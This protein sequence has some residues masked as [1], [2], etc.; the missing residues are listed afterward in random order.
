MATLKSDRPDNISRANSPRERS[1]LCGQRLIPIPTVWG[2]PNIVRPARHGHAIMFRECTI[3]M[4]ATWRVSKK[5]SKNCLK[6]KHSFHLEMK[7]GLQ[8]S[9][10]KSLMTHG[11]IQRSQNLDLFPKN[12][13]EVG[14]M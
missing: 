8:S 7:V 14:Y 6:S 2:V 10:R 12:Q 13:A 5:S 11:S 4:D 9:G 1:L 3:P